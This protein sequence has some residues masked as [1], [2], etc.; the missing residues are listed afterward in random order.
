[1]DMIR[2]VLVV[3]PVINEKENL[4]V[5]IPKIINILGN[6]EIYIINDNSSDGLEYFIEEIDNPKI[7]MVTRNKRLGIGS[8]HILGLEFAKENNFAYCITMDGDQTHDPI[9]LRSL[10][11]T[12]NVGSAD[13]VLTSRFLPGGGL[14]NWSLTRKL[15]T[16]LGHSLTSFIFKS[17]MD[18]T[19]GMRAYRVSSLRSE[20]LNWLRFS[21]Y[22][23]LPLSYYFYS[24]HKM[25][26]TQIPI[27]LPKRIFGRSKINFKL[28]ILNIYSILFARLKFNTFIKNR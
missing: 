27:K 17:S 15:F 1:M 26:I 12:L 9:Y 4:K 21:N 10:Y 7:R 24:S 14:D 23:F 16:I 20:M 3:I 22:E 2:Q 5:L 19:S 6:V 8:A 28:I 18:V 25:Y 13:L 11:E